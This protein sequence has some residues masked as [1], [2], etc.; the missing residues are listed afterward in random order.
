MFQTW[1]ASYRVEQTIPN[2]PAGVYTIRFAF[3]E[4]NNSEINNFADSYAYVTNSIAEEFQSN[5]MVDDEGN[6]TYIPGIGQAF[7]FASNDSQC[8]IVEDVVVTDGEL[9]IGVNGGGSSHTFF[10]E[11]RL[12]LTA[13]AMGFD[14]GKAYQDV[15]EE[16]ESGIDATVAQPAKVRAIELFDLNGRRI[17]SARQGIVFVKKYMSDGTVRTEKVI[18]K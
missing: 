15:L 5:V 17:N 1:G 10:N 2:L 18:K 7:P 4:R 16:I 8:A 11:V 9:T 13:P 3:G 6:E 14:Y 12:Q